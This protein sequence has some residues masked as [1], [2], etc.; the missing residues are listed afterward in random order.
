VL[1]SVVSVQRNIKT[2]QLIENTLELYQKTQEQQRTIQKRKALT[3]Q[4]ASQKHQ[5]LVSNLNK[6]FFSGAEHPDSDE[7]YKH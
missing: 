6:K 3:E 2:P 7:S 4:A 5:K 1:R